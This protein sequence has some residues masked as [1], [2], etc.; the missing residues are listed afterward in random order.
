MSLPKE[1]LKLTEMPGFAWLT[2]RW[3]GE[4]EGDYVEEVWTGVHGG[5][6]MAMFR[7]LKGDEPYL[8]EFFQLALHNGNVQMRLKHFGRDMVGWEER[9]AWTEFTLVALEENY[10]VFLQTNKPNA[11]WLV[12]RRK[13]DHLTV[14]FEREDGAPPVGSAFQFRRG[15]L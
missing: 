8:Y 14:H 15:I 7:W 10:A 5:E 3:I 9:D 11:P 6:I 12:Y 4:I 13:D 1:P 2:G